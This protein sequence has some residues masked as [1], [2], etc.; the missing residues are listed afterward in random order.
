MWDSKTDYFVDSTGQP[1][2]DSSGNV[3]P[4]MYIKDLYTSSKDPGPGQM[5]VE[6]PSSGGG[7]CGNDDASFF[8][9]PDYGDVVDSVPCRNFRFVHNLCAIYPVR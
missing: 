2:T 8:M 9:W 7:V 4:L 6:D 3:V 5:I 1:Y